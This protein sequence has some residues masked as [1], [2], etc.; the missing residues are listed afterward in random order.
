MKIDYLSVKKISFMELPNWHWSKLRLKS[1]YL[2][3]KCYFGFYE[4][5]LEEETMM[6]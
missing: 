3:S 2:V 1:E 6:K 4:V 5:K